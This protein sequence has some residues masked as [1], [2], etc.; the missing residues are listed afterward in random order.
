MYSQSEIPQEFLKSFDYDMQELMGNTVK[1]NKSA[2]ALADE[3]KKSHEE[4][5]RLQA[6]L[7]ELQHDAQSLKGR[8]GE[9]EIEQSRLVKRS[10]E[11]MRT[12]QV[13]NHFNSVKRRSN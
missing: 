10:S 1:L 5:K 8:Q 4:C 3:L 11:D 7:R 12:I 2:D 9:F 13:R 6:D